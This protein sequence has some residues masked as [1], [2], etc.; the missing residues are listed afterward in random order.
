MKDKEEKNIKKD[1]D[2]KKFDKISETLLNTP[3][4]QKK[5]KK[6]SDKRASS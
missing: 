4:E 2:K 5:N 6:S 1:S 3:P